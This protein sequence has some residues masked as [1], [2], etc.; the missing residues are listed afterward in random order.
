MSSYD[1]RI[2][3]IFSCNHFQTYMLWHLENQKT[4][5]IFIYENTCF[6]PVKWFTTSMLYR[7]SIHIKVVS[8]VCCNIHWTKLITVH[9]TFWRLVLE[10][11][12][13]WSKIISCIHT[14]ASYPNFSSYFI[15]I[16]RSLIAQAQSEQRYPRLKKSDI[17]LQ[18]KWC[19]I[20]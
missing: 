15:S 17:L 12:N 13:W 5:V 6:N 10:R 3:L 18:Y 11:K 20:T 1:H 2:T 19:Q 16:V 9:P 8:L 7:I 4:I 14:E